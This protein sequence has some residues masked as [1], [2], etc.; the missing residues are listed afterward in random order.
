M[1][2]EVSVPRA[3][4]AQY[5]ED[6][7]AGLASGLY[8]ARND[9][10]QIIQ[11]P[12]GV[13]FDLLII[14]TEN[15]LLTSDNEVRPEYTVSSQE[16]NPK[17]TTTETSIDDAFSEVTTTDDDA[18]TDTESRGIANMTTLTSKSGGDGSTTDKTYEEFD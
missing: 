2:L 4:L 8:A 3:S 18:Y 14:E 9:Q 6:F 11:N 1:P 5:L 17:T 7:F 16:I 15:A 12:E 10:G 13:Q